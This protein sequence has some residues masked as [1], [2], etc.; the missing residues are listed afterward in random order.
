MN[1]NVN[2]KDRGTD[3]P[4]A[5]WYGAFGGERRNEHHTTLAEKA[6]ARVQSGE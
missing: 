6:A 4:S 3:L 1:N 5:L 2:F